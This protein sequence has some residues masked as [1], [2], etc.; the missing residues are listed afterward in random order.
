MCRQC[1]DAALVKKNSRIFARQRAVS[2]TRYRCMGGFTVPSIVSGDMLLRCSMP[3]NFPNNIEH[4]PLTS[5]YYMASIREANRR[6]DANLNVASRQ[7]EVVERD[8]WA[9]ISS[10]RTH[11]NLK[12]KNSFPCFQPRHRSENMQEMAASVKDVSD[13]S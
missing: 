5:L 9:D 6:R 8:I 2:T 12:L 11:G 7:V 3:R 10:R 1:L 4:M 13:L